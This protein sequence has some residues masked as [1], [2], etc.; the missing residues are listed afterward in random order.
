MNKRQKAKPSACSSLKSQTRAQLTIFIIVAIFIIGLVIIYFAFQQDL[1]KQPLNPDVERV[2]N[3][4]QSCIEEEGIEIIYRI[5]DGGGYYF[6]PNLSTESGVPYYFYNGQ[7]YMLTKKQIEEEISFFMNELLF[8]CTR[9]FVD[10]SDLNISQDEIKTKTTIEDEKV[11]LNVNYPI[12]IIKNEDKTLIKD[13][14]SEIPIRLGIVY[15]SVAKFLQAQIGN[16][17]IC[18]S[19][20]LEISEKN[21]LYV[22]MMDYDEQTTIFVFRDENSKINDETFVW[23]FANRYGVENEEV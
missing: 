21:D 11:I 17:G 10:F 9:N 7:N 22:D 6:P 23:V 1:I 20:L 13:F 19:C 8:F 3:F 2:Y 16:E 18:L 5:G 15:D 4:V 12:T 14:K